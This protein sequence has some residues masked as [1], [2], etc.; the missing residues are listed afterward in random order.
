MATSRDSNGYASYY[1]TSSWFPY[2]VNV[3]GVYSFVACH[4]PLTIDHASLWGRSTAPTSTR[5]TCNIC[6]NVWALIM[7]FS[8]HYLYVLRLFFVSPSWF[9]F[10]GHFLSP[11][12][13]VVFSLFII[14]GPKCLHITFVYFPHLLPPTNAVPPCTVHILP[15]SE[16]YSLSRCRK[17]TSVRPLV[18]G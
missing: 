17:G 4:S 10:W 8:T 13:A 18:G 3:G 2:H 16:F 6:C 11:R 5:D 14:M 1:V 15:Q 9:A 12:I 7:F